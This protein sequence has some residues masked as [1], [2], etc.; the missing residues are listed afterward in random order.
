MRFFC[1]GTPCVAQASLQLG[2][3]SATIAESKGVRTK[4]PN[5]FYCR[6]TLWSNLFTFEQS[7]KTERL[8]KWILYTCGHGSFWSSHLCIRFAFMVHPLQLAPGSFPNSFGN[9]CSRIPASTVQPGSGLHAVAFMAPPL[10]I[11]HLRLCWVLLDPA[12]LGFNCQLDPAYCPLRKSQ[13]RGYLTQTG[14]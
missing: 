10:R 14:L 12:L 1:P 5:R 6:T 8:I 11:C 7:R 4:F 13:W 2:S 9:F 3:A